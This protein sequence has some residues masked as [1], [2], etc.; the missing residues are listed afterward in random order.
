MKTYLYR[1]NDIQKEVLILLMLTGKEYDFEQVNKCIVK[2]NC[3][4]KNWESGKGK[5]QSMKKRALKIK[6][7][8]TA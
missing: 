8:R 7:G 4:K 5:F 1:K 6:S 3:K 2:S